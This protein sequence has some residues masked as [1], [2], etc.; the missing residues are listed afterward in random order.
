MNDEYTLTLE[1]Q[2]ENEASVGFSD[3]PSDNY[4]MRL[5]FSGEEKDVEIQKDLDNS[6]DEKVK[7]ILNQFNIHAQ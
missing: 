1:F 7:D 6:F 5:S 4:S 3:G 2:K